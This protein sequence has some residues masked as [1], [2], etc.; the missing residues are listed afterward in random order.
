MTETEHE[1][2][3]H[4]YRM[5]LSRMFDPRDTGLLLAVCF[6]PEGRPV[7]FNQYVPASLVEGYSL[8]VMRRTAEPDAPKGLVDYVI[9]ET[10]AWMAANGFRGLGLSFAIRR[11]VVADEDRDG[12]WASMDPSVVRHFSDTKQIESLRKFNQKYD[13]RWCPR[14][15]V[16]APH[17]QVAHRGFAMVGAEGIGEVPVVGRFLRA[18]EP[19]R[20]SESG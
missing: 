10:S 19:A 16:T 1:E 4:G 7:A 9:I 12:P 13:P 6:D 3:E 2:T 20:S 8:D 17:L 18:K 5:T 15:V 14:Y 11:E